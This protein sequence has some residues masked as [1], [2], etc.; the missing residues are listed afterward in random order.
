MRKQ[1]YVCFC[2]EVSVSWCPLPCT[3]G[4][5]LR[6]RWIYSLQPSKLWGIYSYGEMILEWLEWYEDM[7]KYCWYPDSAKPTWISEC[8]GNDIEK[9]QNTHSHTM[10]HQLKWVIKHDKHWGLNLQLLGKGCEY[11]TKWCSHVYR[12]LSSQFIGRVQWQ[13][14]RNIYR[15]SLS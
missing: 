15:N 10:P 9:E 12:E 7:L 3:K 13:E 4:S 2:L 5:V 6:L 11:P 1:T 14:S 8:S